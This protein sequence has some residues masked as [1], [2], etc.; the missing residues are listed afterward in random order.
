MPCCI[1]LPATNLCGERTLPA[2]AWGYVPGAPPPPQPAQWISAQTRP[3]LRMISRTFSGWKAPIQQVARPRASM[4]KYGEGSRDGRILHGPALRRLVFA[5]PGVGAEDQ[6][7][8][9]LC[10]ELLLEGGRRQLRQPGGFHHIHL[11][12]LEVSRR[13]R[14]ADRLQNL[15]EQRLRDRA[16]LVCPHR[17]PPLNEFKEVH[18]FCSRRPHTPFWS[19]C[20]LCA[21]MRTCFRFLF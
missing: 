16:P 2:R 5:A 12:G 7:Q 9:G 14:S 20:P 21:S 10:Q 18:H 15:A 19:M 3:G 8:V 1:P 11:I 13:R 4:A 17:L 6:C